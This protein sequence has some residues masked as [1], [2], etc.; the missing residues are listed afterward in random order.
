MSKIQFDVKS[1]IIITEITEDVA[2]DNS[3]GAQLYSIE[4]SRFELLQEVYMKSS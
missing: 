1:S 4:L 2:D 3:K